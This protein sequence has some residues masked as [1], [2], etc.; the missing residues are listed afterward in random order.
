MGFAE[1]E[2]PHDSTWADLIQQLEVELEEKVLKYKLTFKDQPKLEW[3][4]QEVTSR[5]GV[6][7]T[8]L[9]HIDTGASVLSIQNKR[10]LHWKVLELIP[11]MNNDVEFVAPAH[12]LL[13]KAETENLTRQESKNRA[14]SIQASPQAARKKCFTKL[15]ILTLV[16]TRLDDTAPTCDEIIRQDDDQ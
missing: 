12:N 1:A 5:G 7:C 9:A 16:T 6:E 11:R 4:W 3:S 14:T 13:M 2:W 15:D 8:I 10:H